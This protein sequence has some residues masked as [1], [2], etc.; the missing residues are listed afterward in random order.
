MMR[1]LMKQLMRILVIL[2]K[3]ENNSQI[4]DPEEKSGSPIADQLKAS[5]NFPS[6]H[7]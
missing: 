4:Q 7:E 6:S 5:I 2:K 1:H 3:I